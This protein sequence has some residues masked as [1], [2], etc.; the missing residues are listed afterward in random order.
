MA[1]LAGMGVLSADLMAVESVGWATVQ[2]DFKEYCHGCHSTEKQKGD[3][4]LEQ[5]RSLEDIRKQPK[6]W[7]AVVEQMEL[8]EMPPKDKPQPTVERREAMLDW[9]RGVLDQLALE[10]AGDPGPVLLRRLSNAEYTHTIRDLTGVPTLDP[11]QEFP[12]DGAAGEGF[13]NTGQSLVISPSLLTKYLDAAKGVASHAVLLPDRIV[14]SPH[15]TRRDQ[16]EDLLGRIRTLYRT[17]SDAGGADRVNLQGIVFD[18]NEGGRVPVARYLAAAIEEREALT[19]EREAIPRV[20]K[21]RGLSPKYLGILLSALQDDRPSFLLGPIR[22]RWKKATVAD[23]PALAAMITSW[24]A[25]VWKFSPVGHIGKLGGPKAWME[26]VTPVLARQELR[27]KIPA[28]PATGEWTVYLSAGNAGDGVS[29]DVVRWVQPRLSAAGKPEIPVSGI[30]GRVAALEARR[31]RFAADIG[32]YLGAA[33]EA[34]TATAADLDQIA[35]RHGI[36]RGELSLWLDYLGIGP[37]G[38]LKV[39]GHLAT[40]QR[41]VAGHAFVNGWGNPDL[42]SVVANSSGEAVRIPGDLRAHS[43]AMHPSPSLQV[44]AGWLSPVEGPV[45]VAGIVQHAHPECGNGVSWTVEL[46]RGSSRRRLAQGIAHGA[47]EVAFGPLPALSV[48]SGD[49]IS[50]LIGPREGNHSCDLTRVDLTITPADP[51]QRWS[52]AAD[53]SP[54]ITAANPHADR[55]GHAGVWHF[56]TES[57]TGSGDYAAVVPA[58]S[59]LSRWLEM[60]PGKERTQLVADLERLLSGEGSSTTVG[61]DADLR[62]QLLSL[63]GPLL[64]GARLPLAEEKPVAAGGVEWGLDPGSFGRPP[65]GIPAAEV[66]PMDL[67]VQAPS[68]VAI[69]LPRELVAGREF[70]VTG[71]LEPLSGKEGSVQLQVSTNRP[72]VDGGVPGLPLV[73]AEG[74]AARAR[75]EAGLAEFRGL[76]P[77]ALCYTKI[78]P[79]DEVVTLTLHHRED[80]ALRRLM[81]DDGETETLDRL[82]SELRFVSQDALTLVDAFEQLWQYATQDADPKVFEP[83]REPIRERA[84]RFRE[85]QAKAEPLHLQSAIEFARRAYRRPLTEEER[86]GFRGLYQQLRGEGLAHEESIRFLIAR[87]LVAPA[88]LYRAESPQP[89]KEPTPVSEWEMASR[90]SYFL[91]SSLPDGALRQEAAAGRLRGPEAVAK[92]TRR[93]LKDE[94]VRRLAVE[95]GCAWL[96]VHGFDTL[97]EKSERHFP[98]FAGLRGAMYEETIR[99]F[100]DFFQNDR[101]V[102]DLLDSDHTFLNEDLARHYGIPGVQGPEWRRVSGVQRYGRGGILGQATVL[103]TQSGASRTS[104]ILRGNWLCE[105]LLGEKLP[106]PPKDVPQLP[107]DEAGTD[108]MTVRQLVEKH[109]SDTRCSGCHRRID[110]YGF[111]LEAYDAI[112]RRRERDLGDRPV[113]TR[114]TAPD[115][116]E[117]EDMAGLRA[118]LVGKRRDVFVRQFCRKLLGYA[119]GRSVQLSDGPLLK[120]MQAALK[121]NDHRVSAAIET[122]VRSPQFLNIR[123]REAA[124]D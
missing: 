70:V 24:Q 16:T 119:L 25:S 53:V 37:A 67:C 96:H 55:Q 116:T 88:F 33:G 90:L 45:T 69:R 79:V 4:D 81:L 3:L 7:Q 56:Y 39:T 38:A 82:W 110:P 120:E 99:F 47:R 76:F 22:E 93:M 52:L 34:A 71:E 43:V 20:A 72:V 54:D 124:E 121:S 86:R 66:G 101:P 42:P 84:V 21:A 103:A 107:E 15:T 74:S 6:V 83:L 117:F 87:A 5:F 49:L 95:F 32:K 23:V 19:K 106:K 60:K 91:W 50:V 64:G 89:G 113:M 94:K 108:G 68:I 44:A 17:Y 35:S 11:A 111:A 48:Q 112:G 80:D 26:P 78:V 97:D 18:T 63:S 40:A 114:V 92:A 59:I 118:Y 36:T 57:V 102:T 58:G 115:R 65:E 12:V 29:G 28:E 105:V 73:V 61:P 62:R 77:A 27:L 123:G 85:E 14:F 75:V 13:V 31:D 109:S 98:T 10:K 104:P 46:R 9:A 1:L 8:L 122:I 100:T 51:A 41:S 30:R 2:A